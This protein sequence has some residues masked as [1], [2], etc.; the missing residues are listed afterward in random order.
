MHTRFL[1]IFSFLV[2]FKIILFPLK[3]SYECSQLTAVITL[4]FSVVCC[5]SQIQNKIFCFYIY[6]FFPAC[7]WEVE[8]SLN[9]NVVYNIHFQN[10][11]REKLRVNLRANCLHFIW[12]LE[13]P[14]KS[15][16]LCVWLCSYH[17]KGGSR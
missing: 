15:W 11:S 17:G 12:P 9:C 3:G 16:F 2:L 1:W 14:V 4:L 10:H 6:I 8:E 13:P 5:F 7:F